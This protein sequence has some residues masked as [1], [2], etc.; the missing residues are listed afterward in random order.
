MS[1]DIQSQPGVCVK[2]GD[3]AVTSFLISASGCE[4]DFVYISVQRTMI[5]DRQHLSEEE[6]KAESVQVCGD[7]FC[8]HC[9]KWYV[10][11]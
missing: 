8:H 5:V 2:A 11:Y 9:R 6:C 10:S 4:R 1:F 3:Q 7:P